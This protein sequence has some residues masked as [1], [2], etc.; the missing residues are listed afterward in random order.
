MPKESMVQ[1]L[2]PGFV[3]MYRNNVQTPMLGDYIAVPR[4]ST[5]GQTP[6]VEML[7]GETLVK[8]MRLR[9]MLTGVNVRG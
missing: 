9:K 8:L 5:Y 1:V 6:I 3:R 7:P 2:R 4:L